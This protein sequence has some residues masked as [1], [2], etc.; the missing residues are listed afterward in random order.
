MKIKIKVHSNSS[1]EKIMNLG[2]N[3]FEIWIKQ[4]PLEG[5]G[6]VVVERLLGEYFNNKCK[7]L[8]GLRSNRKIVEV[9][10]GN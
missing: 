9:Q 6:N 1:L 5:K 8:S 4:K 3:S 2:E 7:I 10:D